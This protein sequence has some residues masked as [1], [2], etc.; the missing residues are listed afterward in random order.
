MPPSDTFFTTS[1]GWEWLVIL[2]FFFGG[3]AGGSFFL[4]AMV[5][6]FGEER[7]RPLARLGYYTA[8]VSFL[9]AAPLLILDL[10]RPER[11]WHM[12]I[13]SERA[14]L[15]MFK[16]WSPMSV[17]S[18]AL[19]IFGLF[20]FLAAVGALAQSGR[21]PWEPLRVLRHDGLKMII[22]VLGGLVG[23]FLASYTGVLLTV[24]N[25]PIWADTNL[26][27]LLFLFSAAS[28]AAALLL[29]VARGGREVVPTSLGWLERMDRWALVLELLVLIV[30]V[31]SLGA[32]AQAWFNVWGLTLVL[33][34]V[35]VGIL[36][37]LVLEW[38]SDL[39]GNLT[40]PAAAVLVLIG[41]FLLRMVIVMSSEGIREVTTW[42]I[43]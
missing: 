43:R 4:A 7:D 24:T 13:Q 3:L 8:F 29:L 33:G 41:G 9:P 39:L 42:L 31:I 18:W 15:P 6:L 36:V 37:P 17:G 10:T 14:P 23:F 27:G 2:Y 30:A 21:L 19:L 22:A 38:R 5:D 16:W 26:L 28:T 1:P 34:V 25:R 12:L 11:F 35:V 20:S 40:V 32:V